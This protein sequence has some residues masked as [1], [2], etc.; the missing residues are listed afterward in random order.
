[1]ARGACVSRFG[2]S[3]FLEAMR[4]ARYLIDRP[5][6][7][8]FREVLDFGSGSGLFAIAAENAA[9]R[10]LPLAVMIDPFAAAA[11][12]GQCRT[13]GSNPGITADLLGTEVG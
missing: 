5:E 13:E 10:P 6:T 2:P 1:M 8:A 12:A 11:I 4:F 3:P 7:V 9:A